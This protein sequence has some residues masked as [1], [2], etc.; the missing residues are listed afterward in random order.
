MRL[1]SALSFCSASSTKAP[2]AA[3]EIPWDSGVARG[4]RKGGAAA[5]WSA[6]LSLKSTPR[7]PGSAC[8]HLCETAPAFS[9]ATPWLR[10]DLAVARAQRERRGA[11]F[12][13]LGRDVTPAGAG[14]RGE[15]QGWRDYT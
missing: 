1:C 2:S 12:A 13:D 9:I 8:G 15:D 4:K 10:R 5:A 6:A 3:D 14:A 11:A 7:A